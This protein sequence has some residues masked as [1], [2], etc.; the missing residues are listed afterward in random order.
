MSKEEVLRYC[1]STFLKGQRKAGVLKNGVQTMT[2]I[3]V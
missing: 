3:L 2:E 1:L